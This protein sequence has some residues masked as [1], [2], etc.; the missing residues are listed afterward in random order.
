MKV[1][2]ILFVQSM[3]IMWYY[4]QKIENNM[5]SPKRSVRIAPRHRKGPKGIFM[6]SPFPDWN[7]A[8]RKARSA[9]REERSTITSNPETPTTMSFGAQ[10]GVLVKTAALRWNMALVIS[11]RDRESVPASEQQ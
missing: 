8:G 5:L 4:V 2:E 3:Y 6:C 1:K 10:L 11:G 7:N 9:E